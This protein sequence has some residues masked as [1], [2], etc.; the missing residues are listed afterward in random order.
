LAAPMSAHNADAFD[1]Y[2]KWLGIPR[3]QRPITHYQLLSISPK[4]TDAEVIE[5]A[6]I[7]QSTHVRTYQLG[8]HGAL[9]EQLLNEIAQARRVLLNPEKRKEY[10]AT[11]PKSAKARPPSAPVEARVTAR[12]KK[13]APAS[14]KGWIAGLVAGGVALVAAA[15]GGT[16][17]LSQPDAPVKTNPPPKSPAVASLEKK[18]AIVVDVK[19]PPEPKRIGPDKTPAPVK[20]SDGVVQEHEWHNGLPGTTTLVHR[21][22]GIAIF[23]GAGGTIGGW[24]EHAGVGI[25]RDGDWNLDAKASRPMRF[26]ACSLVKL[27]AGLFD[28]DKSA[29]V[30]WSRHGNNPKQPPQE[31]CSEYDG[32]CWISGMGGVFGGG[33]GLRV[34]VVDGKWIFEGVSGGSDVEGEAVVCR[35]GK[36][37]DRAKLRLSE[38]EWHPANG[39]LKLL[40]VGDGFCALTEVRGDVHGDGQEFRL[41]IKDGSWWLDGKDQR[42]NLVVRALRVSLTGKLPKI[43]GDKERIVAKSAPSEPSE[44]EPNID[45]SKKADG[46]FVQEREWHNG[47]PHCRTLMRGNDGIAIFSGAS[48]LFRGVG[49]KLA[50]SVNKAGNWI[51]EGGRGVHPIE[52][53]ACCLTGLPAGFFDLD[54]TTTAKISGNGENENPAPVELCSESEGIC[55]IGGIGGTFGGGEGVRVQVLDGKWSLTGV[56]KGGGITGDRETLRLSEIEWHPPEGPLKLLDLKDGFCV[57]TEVHGHIASPEQRIRLSVKDGAWWL[58]GNDAFKKIRVR[59]LR[60]SLTGN[61]PKV[62]GDK[63]PMVVKTGKPAEVDPKKDVAVPKKDFGKPGR[64]PVPDATAQAVSL[65]KL[66]GLI[67]SPGPKATAKEMNNHAAFVFGLGNGT[68]DDPHLRFVALREA[69]DLTYPLSDPEIAERSIGTLDEE[70]AIDPLAFKLTALSRATS[71]TPSFTAYRIVAEKCDQLLSD[72]I[73]VD[74][75]DRADKIATLGVSAAQQ[76]RIVAISANATKRQNLVRDLER[77]FKIYKSAQTVLEKTPDDAKACAEAG[78]YLALGKGDWDAGLKLLAKGSDEKL[79]AL[80]EKDLARPTEVEAR[81]SLCVA[82]ADAVDRGRDAYKVQAAAR[83]S[84]WCSLVAD[85]VVGL[86]RV[87]LDKRMSEIEKFIPAPLPSSRWTFDV[88]ARD[89]MGDLHGQISGKPKIVQGRL[90][91]S[92]G[93]SM[94]TGQLTYDV[95]DR[96]LEIWVYLPSTALRGKQ[97]ITIGK[98]GDPAGTWDGIIFSNSV[99]GRF[100]PGS[101]HRHRS[102]D[103]D[104]PLE[105]SRPTDLLQLAAVYAPDDTITFY[106]NG[107]VLI[108]AFRTDLSNPE[109][110]LV[111]Y[112]KGEATIRLGGDILMDFEEARLY[113]RALSAAEIAMSYQTFKK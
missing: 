37:V 30:S 41:K 48:G 20:S 26:Y 99:A 3:D 113:S 2:H 57:L 32:I 107:K 65:K 11:L 68:K 100:D 47:M 101:S 14:G 6:A 84:H 42:G 78:A 52:G 95:R 73:A 97:L 60:V 92:S 79:K 70:Y 18:P 109:C 58:E 75:L 82:W 9:C 90:R 13:P 10:D 8:A 27:P 108:P 96:T 85:D 80:A 89:V 81:Q 23:A 71:K 5:D 64:L 61:L 86:V 69:F 106:R 24:E 91:L 19:K 22:E 110:R 1:P 31:L 17:W 111:T 88:N 45:V 33:E 66:H 39:P 53:Q 105:T 103:F 51:L 54:R 63:E 104:I 49:E 36:G 50:V 77:A 46:L 83:A 40:D 25:D 59:A 56:S 21:N 12:T 35:F 72:A 7:R 43:L 87:K 94:A 102:R 16:L 28:L 112:R 29:I 98:T 4:E 62:T 55:W 76:T 74:D 38:V 93:D 44:I 34:H 67:K 15:V